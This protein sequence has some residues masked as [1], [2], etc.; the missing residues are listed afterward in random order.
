MELEIR[1]DPAVRKPFKRP[2][3]IGQDLGSQ[4]DSG[5]PPE[6]TATSSD[7]QPDVEIISLHSPE[8]LLVSSGKECDLFDR[9][10]A[11]QYTPPAAKRASLGS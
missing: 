1:V 6:E 8:A 3:F 9:L 2:R 10:S 11:F 7:S 5:T 4:A